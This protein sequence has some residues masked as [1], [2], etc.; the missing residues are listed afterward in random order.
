MVDT[1]V[2]DAKGKRP[3]DDQANDRSDATTALDNNGRLAHG[4]HPTTCP[5]TLQA[6]QMNVTTPAMMAHAPAAMP[7]RAAAFANSFFISSC[8]FR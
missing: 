8:T 4:N 2:S 1:L 6:Y 3:Q 7:K 5:A